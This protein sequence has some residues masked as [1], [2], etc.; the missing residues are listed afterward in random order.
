LTHTHYG[1]GLIYLILDDK[2]SAF[3]V[4]KILK[5]LDRDLANKLF[6]LIYE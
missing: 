4:Y 1:L 6:D 2:G 5:E 3:E